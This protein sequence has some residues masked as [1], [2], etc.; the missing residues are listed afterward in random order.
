MDRSLQAH[1][2]K[3]FHRMISPKRNDPVMGQSCPAQTL[4][5]QV[6]NLLYR[7]FPIR[8][9]RETPVSHRSPAVSRLEVG[10]TADWKSAL[11]PGETDPLPQATLSSCRCRALY[12]HYRLDG[13]KEMNEGRTEISFSVS[14]VCSCSHL[15]TLK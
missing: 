12:I 11:Q 9:R 1:D 6:S 2:P 3:L 4:V 13:I 14:P 7:G 5:A 8:R 10:D 15:R